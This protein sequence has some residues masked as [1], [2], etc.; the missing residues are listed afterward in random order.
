MFLDKS[1]VSRNF[2]RMIACVKKRSASIKSLG[3]G[4]AASL[5][6]MSCKGVIAVILCLAVSIAT[7]VK[8]LEE[9][10]LDVDM[11]AEIVQEV[12][13]DHFS[14]QVF[15]DNFPDPDIPLTDIHRVKEI[16]EQTFEDAMPNIM[17]NGFFAG[18]DPNELLNYAVPAP[19]PSPGMPDCRGQRHRVPPPRVPLA[20]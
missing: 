2:G 14:G 3:V 5:T 8:D 7:L 12:F 15:R 9:A 10:W 11:Y 6:V 20:R 13:G 17:A 1:P 18:I 16:V 19:G 4:I